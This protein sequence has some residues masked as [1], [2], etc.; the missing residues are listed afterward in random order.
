M[1]INCEWCCNKAYNIQL[2]C[3]WEPV[4]TWWLSP[5]NRTS[6]KVYAPS[7][8]FMRGQPPVPKSCNIIKIV[9]WKAPLCYIFPTEPTRPTD[10]P[11][12]RTPQPPPPPPTE[13]MWSFFGFVFICQ[14]WTP[15]PAEYVIFPRRLVRVRFIYCY[16]LRGSGIGLGC[17]CN[18]QIR[19][20]YVHDKLLDK[21][22]KI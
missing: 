14:S 15:T 12:K 13:S 11:P 20:V 3:Y 5:V 8:S 16:T 17:N 6:P 19:L 2:T 22:T 1:F 10:Y 4:D 21:P 7:E 9:S 18:G